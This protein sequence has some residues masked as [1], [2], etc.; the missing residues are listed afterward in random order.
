MSLTLPLKKMETATLD[1]IVAGTMHDLN[2]VEGKM[3]ECSEAEMIE[4]L[5]LA[6]EVIKD[7]CKAQLELAK[8][9]GAETKREYSHETNDETLKENMR[10]HCYEK[11]YAI[12]HEATPNKHLRGEKFEA[13]REEFRATLSEE[14]RDEKGGMMKRYFFEIEKDAVRDCMLNEAPPFRWQKRR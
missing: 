3:N 11:F 9:V 7:H 10:K 6:H 2:M 5:K 4:A 14:E 13:V 1:I 8:M 12:A